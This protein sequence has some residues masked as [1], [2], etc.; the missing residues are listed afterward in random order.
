MQGKLKEKGLFRIGLYLN[1]EEMTRE[2]AQAEKLHLRRGGLPIKTQKPGGFAGEW[3]A[4]TDGISPLFKFY[5]E[6]YRKTEARRLAEAADIAR[7]EQELAERK[8]TLGVASLFSAGL[9]AQKKTLLEG[10]GVV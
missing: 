9:S 4:N 10:G 5:S 3:I 6:Y 7:Q 1:L 8:E 2:A